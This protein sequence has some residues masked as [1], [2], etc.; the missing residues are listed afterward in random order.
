MYHQPWQDIRQISFM[1]FFLGDWM[2]RSSD[3][4]VGMTADELEFFPSGRIL[5]HIVMNTK[6]SIVNNKKYKNTHLE[7]QRQ[8]NQVC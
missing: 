6:H 3:L 8:L 2:G 5:W 1:I 4:Y 7:I